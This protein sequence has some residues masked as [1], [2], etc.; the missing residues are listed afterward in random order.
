MMNAE[1]K[2]IETISFPDSS[3]LKSCNNEEK[4]KKKMYKEPTNFK[5]K[6][7]KHEFETSY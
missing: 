1:E 3:L 2:K 7:R 5:K 4:E 6:D